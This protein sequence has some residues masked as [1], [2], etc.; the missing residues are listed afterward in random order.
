MIILNEKTHLTRNKCLFSLGII[1]IYFI[2]HKV[3]INGLDMSYYKHLSFDLAALT[4]LT[5]NGSSKQCYVMSLGISPYITASLLVM[6]IMAFRTKEQKARTSPFT[7]QRLT[8]VFSFVIML[9]EACF[10][11][12]ELK[13]LSQTVMSH[14]LAVFE[15]MAGASFVQYLVIKN[16]EHGVGAMLPIILVNMIEGLVS[17]FAKSNWSELRIPLAIGIVAAIIMMFMELSVKKIPLQRVSV[18]NDYAS[19]N[20]LAIKFNPVGFMAIMFSTIC[21]YIPCFGFKLLAHFFKS[22]NIQWI[23]DNMILTKPLGAIVYVLILFFLT[24]LLSLLFVNP[25]DISEGFLYSGDSIVNIPAG[26]KTKQYIFRWVLFLSSLSGL[27]VSS[28]LGLSLFLQF[29]EI[30]PTSLAM[31]PSTLMMSMGIV[32]SL[33]FEIKAFHDFDSYKRFI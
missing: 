8:L 11:A 20:Y 12:L 14:F 5:I 29:K 33:Y 2:L 32:C 22:T 24:V 4:S 27:F 26:K 23:A 1:I 9:G 6:L 18:H 10:Y 3:P 13:Y 17:I 19:K 15:L 30:V 25:K 31:L 28:V 16:K 21:F 7:V